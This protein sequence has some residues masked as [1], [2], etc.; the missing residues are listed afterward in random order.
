MISA[1]NETKYQEAIENFMIPVSLEQRQKEFDKHFSSQGWKWYYTEMDRKYLQ[2]VDDYHECGACRYDENFYV[3]LPVFQSQKE[4]TIFFY[5]LVEYWLHQGVE[6]NGVSFSG[7]CLSFE[8]YL[9]EG[10]DTGTR[11]LSRIFRISQEE[12]F[13]L[14]FAQRVCWLRDYQR[15]ISEESLWEFI[16]QEKGGDK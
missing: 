3:E 6:L 16:H 8:I 1:I 10:W 14:P 13:N 5:Q 7:K 9:C 4:A 12:V 11:I 2:K 15:H